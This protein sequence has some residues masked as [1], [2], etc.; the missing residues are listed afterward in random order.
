VSIPLITTTSCTQQTTDQQKQ[1]PPGHL[2]INSNELASLS[3]NNEQ[4]SLVSETSP[5]HAISISLKTYPKQQSHSPQRQI[6]SQTEGRPSGAG[7]SSGMAD[8]AKRRAKKNS[9]IYKLL[10]TLN[11]FFFVLVTPL[12]LCNSFGL[13]SDQ[14]SIGQEFLYILAYLN[15]S[16]NFLFYGLSCEMY[17]V[18]ACEAL[19]RWFKCKARC[20]VGGDASHRLSL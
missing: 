20:V 14:V 6:S 9:Q 2:P 3:A 5:N 16:L 8:I 11:A 10:L 17:R 4:S 15:H 7:R 18:A 1:Q 19:G 12:V 13:L